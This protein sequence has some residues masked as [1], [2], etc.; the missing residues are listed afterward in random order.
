M[1]DE[2]KKRKKGYYAKASQGKR[3]RYGHYL[4]AGMKGFLITCNNREREVV[5]EAYNLFN[6][7]ADNI[8]GP[9]VVCTIIHHLIVWFVSWFINCTN[10]HEGT[11]V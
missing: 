2:A 3:N 10:V 9:E 4:E 1:G 7:Y 6:E 5:R 11:M 8:Y